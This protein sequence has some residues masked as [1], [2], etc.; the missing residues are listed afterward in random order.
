MRHRNG[1][2]LKRPGGAQEEAQG[3]Q[4]NPISVAPYSSG[5]KL[6]GMDPLADSPFSLLD[7]HSALH[8]VTDAVHE[9]DVLCLA[10][11]CRVLRDLLWKRFPLKWAWTEGYV[12]QGSNDL[13]HFKNVYAASRIRTRDSAVIM[14]VGRLVWA[15]SLNQ[16]WPGSR[17]GWPSGWTDFLVHSAARHGALNSL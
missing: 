9:D 5:L 10:L 12:P 7:L 15:R 4:L 14:T 13:S 2:A 11:T 3:G 17:P 1:V 16:P 6:H 8:L